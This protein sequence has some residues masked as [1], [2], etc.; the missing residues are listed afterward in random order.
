[1][2]GLT[3]GPGSRRARRLAQGGSVKADFVVEPTS[4]VTL[5][6]IMADVEKLAE[7]GTEADNLMT[8]IQ[9][10]MD[11]IAGLKVLITGMVVSPP[12]KTFIVKMKEKPPEPPDEGLTV[13]QMGLLALLSLSCVVSGG[14][15]FWK[16]AV[17][18]AKVNA[19]LEKRKQTKYDKKKAQD[20]ELLAEE[21]EEGG[22]PTQLELE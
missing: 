7:G 12:T 4:S 19:Y 21:D 14:L 3:G 13:L 2:T 5:D 22:R 18:K 6:T 20:T 8:A 9:A 1:M 10:A 11:T 16:R 17:V 15:L